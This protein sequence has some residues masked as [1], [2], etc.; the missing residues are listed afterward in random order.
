MVFNGRC[1]FSKPRQELI[2]IDILIDPKYL[3]IEFLEVDMGN[4]GNLFGKYFVPQYLWGGYGKSD[5]IQEYIS[6]FG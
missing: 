3:K 6:K 1:G 5:L 2:L 4:F